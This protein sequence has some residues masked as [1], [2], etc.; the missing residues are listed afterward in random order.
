MV[1]LII[2]RNGEDSNV[3]EKPLDEHP[4]RHHHGDETV[5]IF[6]KTIKNYNAHTH[7]RKNFQI[8]KLFFGFHRSNDKLASYQINL[9]K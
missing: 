3:Q 7:T 5:C 4:H 2:F 1:Y 8:G 9:F 6:N